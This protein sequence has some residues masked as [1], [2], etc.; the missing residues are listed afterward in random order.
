MAYKKNGKSFYINT[1]GSEEI[2]RNIWEY[3]TRNLPKYLLLLV[4]AVVGYSVAKRFN[5]PL[6]Q[7]LGYSILW[8]CVI[9]FILLMLL[10]RVNMGIIKSPYYIELQVLQRLPIEFEFNVSNTT[11]SKHYKIRGRDTTNGEIDIFEV[12]AYQYKKDIIRINVK[13]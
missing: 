7:I 12:E 4:S 8:F 5:H 1:Y 11:I 2:K 9:L 13:Q 6:Y 10:N 3:H